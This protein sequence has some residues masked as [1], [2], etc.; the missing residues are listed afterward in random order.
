[1][2]LRTSTMI[3]LAVMLAIALLVQQGIYRSVIRRSFLDLE[4]VVATEDL[5]RVRAALDRERDHLSA[6]TFDW[7]AWDDSYD[8]VETLSPAFAEAN[9]TIDTFKNYH[10]DVMAF[11]RS[12]GR[13]VWGRAMDHDDEEA[14]DIALPTLLRDH[15]TVPVL[16]HGPLDEAIAGL[17]QIDDRSLL[18]AARPIIRST[19]TGPSRGTLLVG[20]FVKDSFTAELGAQVGLDLRLLPI[21]VE[22]PA[23][24]TAPTLQRVDNTLLVASTTYPQ[25]D[26]SPG[27]RVEARIPRRIWAQ[28]QAT[29]RFG[30]LFLLAASAAVFALILVLLQ[31]LVLA[32]IERLAEGVRAIAETHDLRRSVV[33][34]RDD[35]IGQ[36][37]RQFQHMTEELREAQEELVA[38][39][40][41]SGMAEIAVGALHNLGNALQPVS[42]TA[43]ILRESITAARPPHLQTALDE[44]DQP[45]GD[46]ARRERLT[47]YVRGATRSLLDEAS[48]WPALA[49]RI[50]TQ[51]TY[52]S[53]IVE[54]QARHRDAKPVLQDV[55]LRDLVDTSVRLLLDAEGDDVRVEVACEPGVPPV[56]AERTRLLQVLQN[57]LLN[58]LESV[59]ES[60]TPGRIMVN[61]TAGASPTKTVRVA[62]ADTGVGFAEAD[63]TAI[64]RAGHSR[65]PGVG[66]GFGLHWSAA[67]VATMGGTLRAHSAGPGRGATFELEFQGVPLEGKP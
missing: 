2:S 20:R 45:G 66:R 23:L 34:D 19:Y 51:T 26:G 1:M 25:L 21:T 56:L 5:D 33:L 65:K 31:R 24:P 27:L 7:S 32:P 47:T 18:V 49:D 61:V 58:A 64:F 40:Y 39:S 14:K 42:A 12:D 10:F 35:E 9:L 15:P 13:L 6:F 29:E 63:A 3:A 43:Q 48:R 57:L 54:A 50:L 41:R 52:A 36:L 28:S 8:Y 30:S 22:P 55:D 44:L 37:S 59:R 11:Y 38:Q 4:S 60:A 17:I 46:P 67:A 62:V 53:Q 16:T